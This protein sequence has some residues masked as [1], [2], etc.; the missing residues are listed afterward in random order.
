MSAIHI[1]VHVFEKL[2]EK[3]AES[4]KKSGFHVSVA[5]F[6]TLAIIERMERQFTSG[7]R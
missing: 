4:E 7:R 6:A 1:P 2:Q 3:L 5:A